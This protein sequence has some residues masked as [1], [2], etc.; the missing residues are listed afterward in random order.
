MTEYRNS[1]PEAYESIYAPEIQHSVILGDN[2]SWETEEDAK[3]RAEKTVRDAASGELSPQHKEIFDKETGLYGISTSIPGWETRFIEAHRALLKDI[4]VE[5]LETVSRWTEEVPKRVAEDIVDEGENVEEV[6]LTLRAR[7]KHDWSAVS[8]PYLTQTDKLGAD[9]SAN[10]YFRSIVLSS[11]SIINILSRRINDEGEVQ[12]YMDRNAQHELMHGVSS[13]MYSEEE[14]IFGWKH[15]LTSGISLKVP[16][17]V[18]E[19]GGEEQGTLLNEATI[20]QYRRRRLEPGDDDFAYEAWVAVLDMADA[21]DPT[22]EHT[23]LR[24]M[25]LHEGRG[26]VIGRFES[27]FGPLSFERLEQEAKHLKEVSDMY[28]FKNK[29]LEMIDPKYHDPAS[30]RFDEVHRLIAQRVD[31]NKAAK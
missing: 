15:R 28:G 2:W 22:Y 5:W 4:E 18:Q 13:V 3:N 11:H 20:E 21:I 8:D 23:R 29:L 6:A 31:R 25:A 12:R 14:D 10:P 16:K 27:I 26:E 1:P 30:E 19:I 7:L 24:A 9:A 17:S